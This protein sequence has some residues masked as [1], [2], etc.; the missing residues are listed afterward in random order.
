M[1]AGMKLATFDVNGRTGFG[2][3]LGDQVAD[4]SGLAGSLRAYIAA[5]P[6]V[7]RKAAAALQAGQLPLMAASTLRWRAP[8]PD[9]SKV[10][11][12]GLNYK[13]HAAEQN[14]PLP[15]APLIF[16]K[17]PNSITGPYD[18]ICWDPALTQQVDYEVELGVVIGRRAR[19]V[20]EAEAL[21]YVFGYTVINDVSARD[22]QFGDKQWVRGKSLDTFCP[23]GP[24]VVTADE[25]PDPQV[26]GV[27]CLVNGNVM[28]DSNT[29]Q[30]VF[31]VR[32]LVSYCSH[33]FTLEPGDLIATGTPNGVGVFRKPPFFLKD[34]DVVR[35]EVESLGY[36]ENVCKFD[37]A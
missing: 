17:F 13:D 5:G 26:L 32:Q 9:P 33:A 4:L 37:R 11:A 31:G 34:G 1:E 16:A 21:D 20:S 25:I 8:V 7:W 14:T 24:L 3:V 30:M 19:R 27:R 2:I 22:L 15:T 29:A 12:I 6:E 10:V 36:L 35:T 18:P 23:V 28:Q